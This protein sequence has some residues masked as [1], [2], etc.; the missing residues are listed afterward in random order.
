MVVCIVVVELPDESLSLLSKSHPALLEAFDTLVGY[1]T[2]QLPFIKH[3]YIMD[4]Y[5]VIAQSFLKIYLNNSIL[6]QEKVNKSPFGEY[7]SSV[8]E[9]KCNMLSILYIFLSET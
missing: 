5:S 1:Q 3:L 6:L 9:E 8:L 2:Y 7:F 4:V